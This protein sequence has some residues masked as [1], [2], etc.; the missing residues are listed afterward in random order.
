MGLERPG[1]ARA[2]VEGGVEEVAQLD[3]GATAVI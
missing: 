2:V 3:V 1:Q